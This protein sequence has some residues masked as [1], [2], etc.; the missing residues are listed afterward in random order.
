MI[1]LSIIIPVYNDSKNLFRLLHTI[2][3]REDVEVL[4]I[5]DNSTEQ[6]D[7]LEDV[8]KFVQETFKCSEFLKN[9][10]GIQSAGT[11]RNIGVDN[12][13]GKWLMFADSDDY[14]VEGWFEIVQNHF[15]S[16]DELIYFKVTS[17][18]E[19]TNKPSYRH[20]LYNNTVS[21]YLR[22]PKVLYYEMQLRFKCN[23]PCGKMVKREVVKRNEISFDQVIASNDEMFSTKCGFYSKN[24]SAYD[25]VIYCVT[26][27]PGSLIMNVSEER[28]WVRLEVFIR[29]YNFLKEHLSR[30]EF[31]N[32][33]LSSQEKLI[34]LKQNGYSKSFCNKVK[35]ELKKNGIGFIT[36]KTFSMNILIQKIRLFLWFIKRRKLQKEVEMQKE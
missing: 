21:D 9:D 29:K 23:G 5:D 18:D 26:S 7:V 17:V 19:F 2:P 13:H 24:M 10:R 20:V 16:E 4:V 11:C 25:D 35:S 15:D 30:K 3:P 27:R 36:P 6:L 34:T 14:F 28:F 32:V 33:D 22:K 8:K 12:A 31:I 1:N